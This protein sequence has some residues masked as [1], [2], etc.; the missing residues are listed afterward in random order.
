MCSIPSDQVLQV[1]QNKSVS[2]K[3]IFILHNSK[4][5]QACEKET[6]KSSSSQDSIQDPLYLKLAW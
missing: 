4:G 6:H 2:Q 1:V 5:F 3:Q